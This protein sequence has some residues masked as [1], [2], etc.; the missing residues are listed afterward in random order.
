M[1][2]KKN[3]TSR[4]LRACELENGQFIDDKHDESPLTWVIDCDLPNRYAT[5][6]QNGVNR[7]DKSGM[8]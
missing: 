5:R 1:M 8:L 4:K 6:G 3:K 7:G 2:G